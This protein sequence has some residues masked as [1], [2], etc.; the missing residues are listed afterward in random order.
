MFGDSSGQAGAHV[1]K[2]SGGVAAKNTA[3]A[4]VN[5]AIATI[6]NGKNGMTNVTTAVCSGA[7]SFRPE[8]ASGAAQP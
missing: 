6:I 1:N 2:D 3:N 8:E 5:A 7:A 4:T